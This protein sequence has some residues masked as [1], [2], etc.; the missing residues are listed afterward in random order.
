[1]KTMAI[2][3]GQ[4]VM[5]KSEGSALLT[6]FQAEDVGENFV[7]PAKS[8]ELYTKQN[9]LALKKFLDEAVK[10]AGWEDEQ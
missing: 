1:M 10:E 4:V 5:F 3:V 6:L 2:N 8:F 7:I 9:I